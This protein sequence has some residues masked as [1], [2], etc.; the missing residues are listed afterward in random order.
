[1]T[2]FR[3][4]LENTEFALRGAGVFC[5]HGYA[6]SHDEAVALVLAAA[7]LDPLSGTEILDR[8]VAPD[9]L[10]R[11]A[12]YTS[13][14]V[15]ERLPVAYITGRAALGDLT[16]HCDPRAL[17]PRSPLMTVIVGD[18]QPWY[19]GR[20]PP[21]I[22]D[23]CCGG[24]S[25]G[26][27]AAHHAPASEVLLLDLDAD[28]VELARLNL[29]E[30]AFPNARCVQGDLLTFVAPDTVDIILA[31]PP[32]VDAED[33]AALPQEYRHEPRIALAAGEDGLDLI[34]R[35]LMQ[36][37][38]VL[39]P[40]GLLFLE[41]GNSAAAL[42]DAYPNLPMI[43]LDLEHGGHGVCVMAKEDLNLL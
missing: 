40:Q 26:L 16:F 29:N 38:A 36:S 32:Y 7:E 21:R 28:A 12:E 14:R 24:G 1:M 23:L 10:K 5:G 20:Q 15:N 31:N 22:V 33:M 17:V 19:C 3:E 6:D 11:L 34:H 25:L 41:V 4:A 35:I 2:T 8:P 42:L 37:K 43:W 30:H 27:L 18:Y 13:L 39:A 9:S